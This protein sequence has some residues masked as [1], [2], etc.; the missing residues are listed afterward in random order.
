M[1]NK[2]KEEPKEES[3]KT[4]KNVTEAPKEEKK[5]LTPEEEREAKA[6]VIQISL[7]QDNGETKITPIR[8]VPSRAM[9]EFM[10]SRTNDDYFKADVANLTAMRLLDLLVQKQSQKR[11]AAGL[12][13]PGAK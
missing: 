8:N 13:I 4:P 1:F 7:Y 12:I 11:T 2:K 9:A 5:K 6:A 3:N 10:I